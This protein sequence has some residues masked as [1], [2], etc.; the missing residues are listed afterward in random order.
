MSNKK[1][2]QKNIDLNHKLFKFLSTA[3][4]LPKLPENVSFVPFSYKNNALNEANEEL[5]KSLSSEK[6]PVVK[7]EEPRTSKGNWKFT[8][9]NF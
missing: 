2:T 7:A 4:K 1:Q 5:L 6:K 8:P 3:G 9:V